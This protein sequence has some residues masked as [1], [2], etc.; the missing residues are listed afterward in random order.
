LK[1]LPKKMIF[2]L[3]QNMFARLFVYSSEKSLKN[4]L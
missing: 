1:G 3:W 2:A 4:K